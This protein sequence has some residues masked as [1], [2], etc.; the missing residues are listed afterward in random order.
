MI[1]IISHFFVLYPTITLNKETQVFTKSN[2][3]K[4][5][6]NMVILIIAGILTNF[7]LMDSSF[8]TDGRRENNLYEIFETLP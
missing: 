3:G 6:V 1:D 7:Y 4:F 5:G 2:V 8:I